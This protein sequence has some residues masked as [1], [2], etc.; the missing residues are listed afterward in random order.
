MNH[1]KNYFILLIV[2]ILIIRC[3]GEQ[4]KEA[5]EISTNTE[6]RPE[7]VI[8]NEEQA[9]IISISTTEPQ[10]RIITDAIKATGMLDVPPQNL[11]TIA[12]P[13]GG[14]VSETSLLQGT[15]VK[16]GQPLVKLRHPNYIKLQQE[17]LESSSQLILTEQEWKR[18]E[19]LSLENI[20][21]QKTLQ[22]ARS[23]YTKAKA[24]YQAVFATL[25]LINLDGSTIQQNG[26]QEEITINSPISGYV[27]RVEVNLGMYVAPEQVMFKIIDTEHLH[28]ELQIFE[29]DILKIKTGQQIRI[30]LAN[31]STE[32]LAKVYLIGK[33]ISEDRTVRVHGHLAQH[34]SNLLPGM[35]L[36]AV[37]ETGTKEANALPESCFIGFEGTDFVFVEVGKQNY[38]MEP[39]TKGTCDSGYCTF[40]FGDSAPKG[41]IVSS[42]NNTLLGLLKNK[43]EE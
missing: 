14:F 13:L 1:S 19:E 12:A 8:L 39:V 38:K 3:S 37:V 41:K 6:A 20:N 26:I 33:E 34:D 35:F 21:S 23:E 7:T 11:V 31:E 29:K 30:R 5:Q 42:G 24:A 16:K 28:A 40:A 32:R 2:A 15:K 4:K 18:Q 25:K 36:S 43:P 17:Y 27:T 10:L 9:K 22:L